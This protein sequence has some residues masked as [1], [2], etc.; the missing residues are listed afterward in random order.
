M[1]STQDILEL[2]P[3]LEI[4]IADELED[5]DLDFKQWDN[6]SRD[7][8]VQMVVRMA[9]CMA[10]GGGGT[11]VFGVA[12][13]VIGRVNALLGIPLE[14]DVNLLKKAVYDQTDPKIMPVFENLTVPEGSGRLLLMHIH[15]GRPPYTDTSGRGTVRVGKDCQPLTGTMRRK[16]AVETGENDYTA[17]VVAARI[18]DII[19]SSAMETLRAM[20]KEQNAPTDLLEMKDS[21]L[22]AALGVLPNGKVT[23]AAVLLCGKEEAIRQYIPGHHW[24]FL[25]MPSDIQYDIR[26]DRV[27]A[28]PVAISRFED[29]LLPFNPITTVEHGLYHFE[30]CTFP[31]IAFREALM[32]AFCHAD[33]R[34]AG[35]IL[36][37]LFHNQMTISNNGGFIAGITE[38]NILHHQPAA[39][40]PMLVEA[41]TRIR[42]VNR[43][44]LGI[45]RMFSAFLIEG[46]QPPIIQEVG[47]SVAVT[48]LR[49]E[50]D[51]EVRTMIANMDDP[52][53]AVDELMTLSFLRQHPLAD[54]DQAAQYCQCTIKHAAETLEALA[55]RNLAVTTDNDRQTLWQLSVDIRNKY[56]SLQATLNSRELILRLLQSEPE[57]G[58]AIGHLI[59]ESGISRSSVKRLLEQLKNE[60]TVQML[61][62]GSQS[63]WL[64]SPPH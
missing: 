38:K 20:A 14:I 8:S 39:R 23:K 6:K 51:A 62:K 27:S 56:P 10:N 19:S 46:K 37:K 44:N 64:Y 9:V 59:N 28:I 48:F 17:E 30:Y 63:V 7:K 24:I 34:I 58:L 29:L 41:L 3:E 49:S 22:L 33:Y 53:L 1:R 45:A 32:N 26:E 61:G 16:I 47:E 35:P 2:L 18:Q 43:S 21:Q 25:H 12:D 60:G 42:L 11:V 57:K 13:H 5:Q 15:P 40:N 52:P 55:T 4:R 36:V 50:I 54:I 31:P